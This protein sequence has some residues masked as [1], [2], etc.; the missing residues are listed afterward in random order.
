MPISVFDWTRAC[1]LDTCCDEFEHR[2][3][4]GASPQLLPFPRT[5][6]V[7]CLSGEEDAQDEHGEGDADVVGQ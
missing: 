2:L 3:D 5:E 4:D 6:V 7:P 1:G